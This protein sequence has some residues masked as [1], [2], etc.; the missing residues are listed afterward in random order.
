MKGILQ[1]LNQLQSIQFS[2]I[3]NENDAARTSEL[4]GK[5]PSQILGHY[6]RFVARGKKGIAAVHHQT[7][8]AC[9]M[10]VPLGAILTLQRGDDIQMCEN[11]G[12]YLYLDEKSVPVES[13]KKKTERGKS[14]HPV[15]V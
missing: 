3:K 13:S 7:C 6:D 10:S 4:R 11:C 2:E 15:A 9:H 5:I 8:S 1:N 12:R 14:V